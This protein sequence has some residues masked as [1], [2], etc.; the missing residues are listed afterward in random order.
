MRFYIAI[1]ENRIVSRPK[2]TSLL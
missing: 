1:V 2:F